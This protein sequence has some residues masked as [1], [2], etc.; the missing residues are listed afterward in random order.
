MLAVLQQLLLE[1]EPIADGLAREELGFL[2]RDADELARRGIPTV[3]VTA[4]G[5]PQHGDYRDRPD[6]PPLGDCLPSEPL[7][8]R[9]IVLGRT[10][11]PSP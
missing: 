3:V 5:D 1:A 4:A 10:S 8:Q 9:G 2:V 11:S 7:I 6:Q